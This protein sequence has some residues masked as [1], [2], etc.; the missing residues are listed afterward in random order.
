MPRSRDL[1]FSRRDLLIVAGASPPPALA[2]A[3]PAHAQTI[4]TQPAPGGTTFGSKC[5]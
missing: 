3:P 2:Q 4:G 1:E 5:P